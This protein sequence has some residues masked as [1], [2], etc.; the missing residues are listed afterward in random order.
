VF[1]LHSVIGDNVC[2]STLFHIDCSFRLLGRRKWRPGNG[3]YVLRIVKPAPAEEDF[4]AT[5]CI[6]KVGFSMF[7]SHQRA[8]LHN[9]TPGIASQIPDLT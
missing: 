3:S 1:Q 7:G 9:E 2:E 4:D 8:G 5:I 6:A